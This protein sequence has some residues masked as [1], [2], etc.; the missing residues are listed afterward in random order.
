MKMRTD[1]KIMNSDQVT[2]AQF[3]TT[4]GQYIRDTYCVA[5]EALSVFPF[6]LMYLWKET[7][8]TR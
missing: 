7:A 5:L 4:P 6:Y 8:M 3:I 2:Y 1:I